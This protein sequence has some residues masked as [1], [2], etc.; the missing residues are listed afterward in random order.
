VYQSKSEQKF[1]G[2]VN[3]RWRNRLAGYFGQLVLQLVSAERLVALPEQLQHRLPGWRKPR[4]T[5]GAEFF[6]TA[7]SR[8]DTAA[9]VMGLVN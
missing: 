9:V 7:Q 6:C 2:S 8:I 1:N 3:S 4:L 5:G